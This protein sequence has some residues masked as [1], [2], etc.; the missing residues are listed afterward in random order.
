LTVPECYVNRCHLDTE[1]QPGHSFRPI[2]NGR[3]GIPKGTATTE[4]PVE[5]V[6]LPNASKF[7]KEPL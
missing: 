3:E 6:N 7:F 5:D 1:S 2:E 4:K